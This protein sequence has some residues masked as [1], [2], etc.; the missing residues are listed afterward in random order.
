MS[1]LAAAMANVAE[2]EAGNAHTQDLVMANARRLQELI[3]TVTAREVPPGLRNFI[4]RF[5]LQ[6]LV[7]CREGEQDGRGRVEI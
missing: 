1:E 3:A 2:R 6:F 5:C 7:E 4:E